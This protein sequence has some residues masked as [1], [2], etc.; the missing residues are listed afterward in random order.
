MCW[1]KYDIFCNRKVSS[2]QEVVVVGQSRSL[3]GVMTQGIM[4]SVKLEADVLHRYK[5]LLDTCGET[6]TY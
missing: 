5:Q 2:V 4:T 1:E 3:C 6:L